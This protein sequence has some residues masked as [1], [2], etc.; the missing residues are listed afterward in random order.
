MERAAAK[1]PDLSSLLVRP[2]VGYENVSVPDDP[3]VGDRVKHHLIGRIMSGPPGSYTVKMNDAGWQEVER[4]R[5]SL[6]LGSDWWWH[7]TWEFDPAGAR[8][9]GRQNMWIGGAIGM[10]LLGFIALCA[11]WM[12]GGGWTYKT[13]NNGVECRERT[14]VLHQEQCRDPDVDFGVWKDV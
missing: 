11:V 5:G 12:F 7:Y 6:R 4:R 2:P 10:V 13:Y 3:E 1:A 8:K 14:I 9:Q